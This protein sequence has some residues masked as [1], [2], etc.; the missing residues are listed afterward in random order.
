[1]SLPFGI[2]SRALTEDCCPFAVPRGKQ[3]SRR[4]MQI[5]NE[6][7]RRGKRKIIRKSL[8]WICYGAYEQDGPS[9]VVANRTQERMVH[10]HV[11]WLL[12]AGHGGR[13]NLGRCNSRRLGALFIYFSE[14]LVLHLADEPVL[15]SVE[16]ARKVRALRF[17][18]DAHPKGTQRIVERNLILKLEAWQRNRAFRRTETGHPRV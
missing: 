7:A 13:T 11:E 8:H 14:C 16:H 6:S 1:M 3:T 15:P 17:K 5:A 12:Y 2:S 10:H 4:E 9:L 18:G